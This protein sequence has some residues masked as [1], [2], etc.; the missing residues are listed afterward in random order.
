MFGR[1][2]CGVECEDSFMCLVVDFL[3][4]KTPTHIYCIHI[5]HFVCCLSHDFQNAINHFRKKIEYKSEMFIYCIKY[6]QLFLK[7]HLEVVT[8]RK[9]RLNIARNRFFVSRACLS[10]VKR[11]RILIVQKPINEMLISP[12]ICYL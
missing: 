2:Y 10:S 7:L 4:S 11:Y 12:L 5:I 8:W 1:S 9:I 3:T 6:D